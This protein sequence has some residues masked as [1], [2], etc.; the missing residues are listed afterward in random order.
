MDS[1]LTLIDSNSESELAAPDPAFG[2]TTILDF[3]HD[4]M[5]STDAT[6]RGQTRI[7]YSVRTVRAGLVGMSLK[8]VFSQGEEILATVQR[9]DMIP[10][11]LT[12]G[13]ETMSLRSWLKTP[14]FSS[15]PASFSEGREMYL[16]KKGQGGGIDLYNGSDANAGI[17]AR[18]YPSYFVETHDRRRIM[19]HAHL[20]LQAEADLIREKVFISCVLIVQKTMKM[21]ARE[22]DSI[23]NQ[24]FMFTVSSMAAA[25]E[26]EAECEGKGTGL[27]VN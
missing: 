12:L 20:D 24:E 10:D 18:F 26:D 2:A 21:K 5:I 3:D 15:F 25:G 16:W 4:G 19:C 17:I 14:M 1:Q 22:R 9:R 23:A 8:T 11:L 13:G 27:G 7:R 6:V